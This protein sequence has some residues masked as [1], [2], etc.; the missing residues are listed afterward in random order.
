LEN[1]SRR[2][3]AVKINEGME[4]LEEKFPRLKLGLNQEI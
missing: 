2:N 4:L 1:I 3:D